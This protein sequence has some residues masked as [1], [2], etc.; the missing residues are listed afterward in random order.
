MPG[1]V[2]KHRVPPSERIRLLVWKVPGVITILRDFQVFA[3]QSLI[4]RTVTGASPESL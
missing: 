3:S 2:E 4:L 1:T